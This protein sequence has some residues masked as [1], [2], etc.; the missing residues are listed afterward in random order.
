MKTSKQVKTE[1]MM[2]LSYRLHHRYV[3]TEGLNFSDVFSINRAGYSCDYEIKVSKSDLKRELS[4][5]VDGE[6]DWHRADNKIQK[7][8]YYRMGKPIV[9]ETQQSWFGG[10]LPHK[11]FVPN[12]FCFVIPSSLFDYLAL[13][14]QSKKLPYGIMV[15]RDDGEFDYWMMETKIQPTFLHKEKADHT[16]KEFML[17]RAVNELVQLRSEFCR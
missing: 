2:F 15:W 7:H 13:E 5:I 16:I 1:L 9:E 14:I 6:C 4:C 10:Y 17:D 12:K 3:I 11:Y 8:H